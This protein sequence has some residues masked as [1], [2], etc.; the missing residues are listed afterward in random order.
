MLSVFGQASCFLRPTFTVRAL[1]DLVKGARSVC[2][3]EDLAGIQVLLPH[4]DPC[5]P[6]S[7][8]A[9]WP[10]WSTNVLIPTASFK[11]LF[12]LTGSIAS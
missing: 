11:I 1:H 5:F 12:F 8:R 9:E 6:S 10:N 7:P 2:T 4:V 3:S